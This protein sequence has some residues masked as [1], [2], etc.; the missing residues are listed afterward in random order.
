MIDGNG[1]VGHVFSLQFQPEKHAE[2]ATE[3]LEKLEIPEKIL[4]IFEC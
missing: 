1:V 2:E 4:F 3:T